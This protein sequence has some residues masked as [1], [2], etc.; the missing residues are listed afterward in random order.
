MSSLISP[1]HG[2][3]TVLFLAPR[4]FPSCKYPNTAITQEQLKLL[5]ARIYDQ[6]DRKLSIVFSLLLSSSIICVRLGC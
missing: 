6:A 3:K 2:N 1:R 5:N 4:S